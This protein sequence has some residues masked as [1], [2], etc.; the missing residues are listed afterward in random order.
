MT[1]LPGMPGSSFL[2]KWNRRRP[3]KPLQLE[4]KQSLWGWVFVAPAILLI[5]GFSFI[6]MFQAAYL[7]L[8]SGIANNLTFN[9]VKT[10]ANPTGNVFRNYFRLTQDVRFITS[11]KNVFIYLIF[12]VPIM[13]FLALVLA[14]ILNNKFLPARG[15]FRT[16]VFLPCAVSLVAASVTFRSLYSLDGL[17]NTALLGLKIIN[18]PINWLAHGTWAKVVIIIVITWRWTG[19]NTI[20]YLAGFQNIPSEIYEAA[21]IDGAN[22]VQQFTKLTLP[23]LRPVILLTA[24]MSTNGTLQIFDEP[25]IITNG[26]PA[27][28]TMSI[29]QYI[30]TMSFINNPQFGYAAAAAFT[31]LFMVAAL[32]LI[33]LKVGDKK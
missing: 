11:V 7:S 18:E 23:L 13:L 10:A 22:A 28:G 19:Y 33:Q 20:F 16:L 31:I 21:R 14:S 15:F 30:Y 4:Q 12:Q 1:G 6:P 29:S 3:V 8:H 9:G 27:D 5:A 25:R 17:V 26:G 32:S 24:I 2:R